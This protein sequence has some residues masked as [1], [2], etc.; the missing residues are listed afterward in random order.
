[1]RII[2]NVVRR[3]RRPH[4]V[5][6]N[7][8]R[9][10]GGAELWFLDAA[11]GLAGRGVS[12][13]LVAQP[14]SRLLT[15]ARARG[16]D[17][18][19]IP[20]RF[21]AAPWTLWRLWRRLRRVGATALVCNL[22]K[23]LKAAGVAGMLAGVPVRLASRESDFPLK[24]KGYYRWYFRTAATGVLVGSQATGE[25][26]LA[27]APWLDPA[28]VHLLYKGIDTTVFTPVGP[29]PSQR[30]PVAGFVGQLI[31]RKGL[32][33]LMAAWRLLL[34]RGLPADTRLVIV[35]EGPLRDTIA[36]WRAGLPRPES[37]ELAGFIDDVPALWSRCRAG[38]LPSRAEG[39]GLAAAEASSCGLP[40]VAADASSLPEVVADGVTGLLVPPDDPAAL[41]DALGRVLVDGDLADRLGAAGRRRMIDR[42]DHQRCLDHLQRLACPEDPS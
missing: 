42:F 37:V 33:A 15:E 12:V 6:V 23:D 34:E 10:F 16:L 39:F 30:P 40:V 35:G 17:T 29:P 5:F 11:A 36:G 38:V 14:G 41:A 1:L 7:S 19:A 25:T 31:E 13:S 26:V 22:T 20:I 27:S 9:G 8:L 4:V 28:R 18:A 21:D 32:A 3:S 24:N 2:E